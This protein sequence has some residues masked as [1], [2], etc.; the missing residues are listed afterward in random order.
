MFGGGRVGAREDENPLCAMGEGSPNLGAVED[1]AAVALDRVSLQRRQVRAGIGFRIALAP[2]FLTGESRAQMAA[3]LRVGAPMNQRG[4]EEPDAGSGKGDAGASALQF[5]IADDLLQESAAA[6]AVL[7]RPGDAE[8]SAFIEL[9]MPAQGGLPSALSFI[10]KGT[11][12]R[13]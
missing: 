5:L 9:V 2:K 4:A 13:N 7:T 11:A 10:G 1:K 8:T 6:S 3:F 12:G